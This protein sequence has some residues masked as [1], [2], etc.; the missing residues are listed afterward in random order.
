MRRLAIAVGMVAL[1]AVVLALLPEAPGLSPIPQTRP[2]AAQSR[3]D[4]ALTVEEYEP[5]ST[6]VVDEHPVARARFPS[7]TSTATTGPASRS[8]AG[9][10]SSVR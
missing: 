10:A 9:T 8:T 5:R 4:E 6:L 2:T 3:G 1:A 7:S